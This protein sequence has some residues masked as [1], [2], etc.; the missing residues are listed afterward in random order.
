MTIYEVEERKGGHTMDKNIIAWK[1][2][3]LRESIQALQAAQWECGYS[4]QRVTQIADL[5][6]NINKLLEMEWS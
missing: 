1:V 2:R 5:K 4:E 6:N 3:D